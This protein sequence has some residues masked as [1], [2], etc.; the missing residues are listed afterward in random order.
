MHIMNSEEMSAKRTEVRF[1][2]FDSSPRST[3]GFLFYT[4]DYFPIHLKM[5]TNLHNYFICFSLLFHSSCDQS[6]EDR[7]KYDHLFMQHPK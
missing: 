6:V 5:Q 3:R 7:R 4:W 2:Y 1:G